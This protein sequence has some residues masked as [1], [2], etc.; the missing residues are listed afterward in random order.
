MK[1]CKYISVGILLF[2]AFLAK[3]QDP[4]MDKSFWV[5][6]GVTLNSMV[7]DSAHNQLILGGEFH[8]VGPQNEYMASLNLDN[9]EAEVAPSSPNG[10][11][12]DA[13]RDGEGGWF[14]GGYFSKVG[15]SDRKNVAHI[16]ADGTLDYWAPEVN[17]RVKTMIL[18]DSL[19]YIGGNFDNINGVLKENVAAL[20]R[21]SGTLS[22][23]KGR[24]TGDV[25][26]LTARN[27]TIYVGGSFISANHY[28]KCIAQINA[29]TGVLDTLLP[30]MNA[31]VRKVLSDERGGWY[32]A[33]A[34]MKVGGE[35]RQG[36]AHIKG[37]GTLSAWNPN[38]PE[39]KSHI[40]DMELNDGDLYVVG[41]FTVSNDSVYRLSGL[42]L[43][44][45]T[46]A[47]TV[48]NPRYLGY[49]NEIEIVGDTVYAGG[50][51]LS[52]GDW[53]QNA[54]LTDTISGQNYGLYNN[55]N[56]AVL[57]SISDENEGWYAAGNFTK[58][59]N[60][61]AMYV[62]HFDSLGPVGNFSCNA[63][64]VKSLALYNGILYLGGTFTSVNDEPAA[65]L[66]A[67]NAETGDLLP[68]DFGCNGEVNCI[69]IVD[70]ILYAA[71]LFGALGGEARG[72]IGA[73]NLVNN[74]VLDWE[75][76]FTDE[77]KE[78]DILDNEIFIGGSFT[79]TA[80]GTYGTIVNSNSAELEYEGVL[81]DAPIIASCPDGNNGWYI[82][83]KFQL[84]KD[85]PRPGIGQVNADGSIGSW[86]HSVDGEVFEMKLYGDTL[87]IGGEFTTVNGEERKNFAAFSISNNT[88]LP[89]N[90]SFNN[91]VLAI[92][93]LEN[94]IFVG[95]EFVKVDG[96]YRNRFAEFDFST[97]TLQSW[98]PSFN[99]HV[100]DMIIFLNTLYVSGHFT[101]MYY[102]ERNGLASFDLNDNTLTDWAPLCN[103][104]VHQID[105]RNN[106]LYI[107]GNFTQIDN[108]SA[109]YIAGF[110]ITT[111][112]RTITPG[113]TGVNHIGKMK[114][115]G[116]KLYY[117]STNLQSQ[118]SIYSFT[119]NTQ[120]GNSHLSYGEIKT[121]SF[122]SSS[123]FLGGEFSGISTSRERLA[124]VDRL[125][126]ALLNWNP[127]SNF[128]VDKIVAENDNVY[129][130]GGFTEITETPRFKF[131][132]L[133][134]S[135]GSVLD[136]TIPFEF[137]TEIHDMVIDSGNLYLIGN[138]LPNNGPPNSH[139]S[140]SYRLSDFSLR[141][142]HISL[143]GTPKTISINGSKVFAGGTFTSNN[144]TFGVGDVRFTNIAASNDTDGSI[145]D[146]SFS[147][148][149]MEVF[150]L[151]SDGE[152]L[153]FGGS[154]SNVNNQSRKNLACIDLSTRTLLDWN[155]IAGSKV[156]SLSIYGDT[157]YL[158]GDFDKLN[159][160][161]RNFIGALNASTGETLDWNPDLGGPPTALFVNETALYV[162]GPFF[163]SINTSRSVWALDRVTAEVLDWN[164]NYG[165][166]VHSIDSYENQV[167]VGGDFNKLNGTPRMNLAA[168][169]KSSGDLLDW[170]PGFSTVYCMEQSDYGLFVGGDG[171]L[172]END[173]LALLSYSSGSKIPT[174]IQV[175]YNYNNITT[176]KI[177]VISINGNRM[178]LGGKF[179]EVNGENRINIAALNLPDFT[180]NEW[181]IDSPRLPTDF[182]FNGDTIWLSSE[183]FAGEEFDPLKTFLVTGEEID[184]HIQCH[185]RGINKL[186]IEANHLFAFGGFI[187][188]GGVTRQNIAAIDLT[189]GRPNDFVI[190]G[191]PKVK[192]LAIHNGNLYIGTDS[193]EEYPQHILSWNL[194][195]NI[196]NAEWQPD[197]VIDENITYPNIPTYISSIYGYNNE[198][199]ATTNNTISPY[200]K[201]NAAT[202]ESLDVNFGTPNFSKFKGNMNLL[203]PNGKYSVSNPIK[204]F[205]LETQM[206]MP[207][208]I[209]FSGSLYDIH[210]YDGFFYLGGGYFDSSQNLVPVIL[211]LDSENGQVEELDP[212]GSFPAI[213]ILRSEE[214][215]F[216]GSANNQWVTG[217]FR[218]MNLNTNEIS[219]WNIP[220]SINEIVEKNGLLTVSYAGV[221]YHKKLAEFYQLS[222]CQT[223]AVCSDTLIYL[224]DEGMAYLLPEDIENGSTSSCEISSISLGTEN[225]TCDYLGDNNIGLSV[226][227]S[228]GYGASCNALITVIDTISPV[229]SVSD[230]TIQ[231]PDSGVLNLNTENLNG[232]AT[233]NC[234][235][236]SIHILNGNTSYTCADQGNTFPIEVLVVDLSGNSAVGT[237]NM[238]IVASPVCCATQA[239]VLTS[240]TTICAGETVDIPIELSGLPPFE[241]S[242]AGNGVPFP[243]VIIETQTYTLTVSPVETTTYTFVS[244]TDL[245]CEGLVYNPEVTIDLLPIIDAGIDADTLFCV[246][247]GSLNLFTVFAANINV[248]GQF[249]PSYG[250]GQL[251]INSGLYY[252][253]VDNGVCGFDTATF[254]VQIADTISFQNVTT[255]CEADPHFYQVSFD[256]EGGIAP[257]Q[258]NTESWNDPF[259]ESELISILD[260]PVA[261]FEVSDNSGCPAQSVTAAIEDTDSDGICD[262]GEIVGCMIS[263]ASNYNPLATDPGPCSF[264]PMGN[265][266]TWDPDQG[267]GMVGEGFNGN[268]NPDQT[269]DFLD[270]EVAPNPS[271][272][273]AELKAI[274][275]SG[276]NHELSVI[277]IYSIAGKK[278]L[279]QSIE[280]EKGYNQVLLQ[281]SMTFAAGI[282]LA[283][284]K[285][286]DERITRK[287]VV[288]R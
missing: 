128:R 56:G 72:R 93:K 18:I 96:I 84:L 209:N 63:A 239:T 79:G 278:L 206:P 55:F 121:L 57:E 187:S 66:A 238:T 228:D 112:L 69:K 166:G 282:Y 277:T 54:S 1:L 151:A 95:G 94:R 276:S 200:V 240:D 272:S 142:W 210:Y 274:I 50:S 127:S 227:T 288:T 122:N 30:N 145:L 263:E 89:W 275:H 124:A 135:T 88:L 172:N 248:P 117:T 123:I 9:F 160:I 176:S 13:V 3:A 216:L 218:Y 64:G 74:Q 62:A 167:F 131:A 125:T 224:N 178:Y 245:N 91:P 38:L 190:P 281:N 287:V 41:D 244:V 67:V 44:T 65:Y 258:V 5:P 51:F 47:T 170:N 212:L 232:I 219:D 286:G 12:Y 280:I 92:E 220:R 129:I 31:V 27:D 215:L 185:Y 237:V 211:K 148:S 39:L 168:F 139:T 118:Y 202:G 269:T 226:N 119:T 152:R 106:V 81:A 156:K 155:P 113:L 133:S 144:Y 271:T 199:Y 230:Y 161:S 246:S 153:F 236:D 76:G 53:A 175:E 171:K 159:G 241:L 2:I 4:V 251:P 189:T 283:E 217:G 32:I 77:I 205:D 68:V 164:L 59:N 197:F 250:L 179:R 35:I 213:A 58:L 87:I 33:G 21:Y 137:N 6:H 267:S 134:A 36:L 203:I 253:I 15:E 111:G 42:S 104:Y 70:N 100:S 154:F 20:N 75:T 120:T 141:P 256:I 90:P 259:Y 149:A 207:W 98:E 262:A 157:L 204:V 273:G 99:N 247:G 249:L 196:F 221:D 23:W 19:L 71:G 284:V 132:T 235:I 85:L 140:A 162:G 270:F 107:A 181:N 150:S 73:I 231:I 49:V 165:G 192:S 45:T 222:Q 10:P 109:P 102:A 260:S 257:F 169:T 116:D 110:N 115:N 193:D 34:F 130:H 188:M 173:P 86:S 186:E 78:F 105:I 24:T 208:D 255:T 146:W 126:G 198:I 195:S 101:N 108:Q 225:F 265:P 11:I 177:N 254:N 46:G 174:G 252:F 158:I 147:A 234:S 17:G 61:T 40:F 103:S 143:H 223:N 8:Y 180:L 80:A 37:N 16:L 60:R 242:F 233:D 279:E 163:Q 183:W 28:G 29:E 194:N 243:P 268:F 114:I 201:L 214:K 25:N 82:A 184:T 48:W 261:S 264:S 26:V 229:I 136:F 7:T 14:I 285:Y 52:A 22:D 83:G 266:S 138:V 182:A 191:N 97:G 43:D